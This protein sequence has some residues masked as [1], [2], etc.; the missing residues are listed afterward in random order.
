M[1]DDKTLNMSGKKYLKT[2]NNKKIS[3]AIYKFWK[4]DGEVIVDGP[5][6]TTITAIAYKNRK[7]KTIEYIT[8]GNGV[9]YDLESFLDEVAPYKK[10]DSNMKEV[11]F[12]YWPRGKNFNPNM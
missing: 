6:V 5:T 11:I 4:D 3:T 9:S 12:A 8:L 10:W 2:F 1:N 7:L